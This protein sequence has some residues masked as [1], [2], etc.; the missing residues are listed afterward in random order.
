MLAVMQKKM[1]RALK[2]KVF[3]A[4]SVDVFHA[5]DRFRVLSAEVERFE[6]GTT[7]V[8][9]VESGVDAANVVRCSFLL[10]V[11]ICSCLLF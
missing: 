5:K 2:D 6:F 3:Y 7:G 8:L 9:N 1:R 4:V 11:V 10:L